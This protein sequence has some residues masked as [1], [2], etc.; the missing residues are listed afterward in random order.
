MDDQIWLEENKGYC[1]KRAREI[2][3]DEIRS[4]A[5]TE[6]EITSKGSDLQSCLRQYCNELDSVVREEMDTARLILR[7]LSMSEDCEA[8]NLAVKMMEALEGEEMGGGK[9]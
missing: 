2:L 4:G 7:S 3:F 5:K 8:Y 1:R 9:G 6:N